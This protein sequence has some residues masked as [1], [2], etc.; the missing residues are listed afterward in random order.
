MLSCLKNAVTLE[1]KITADFG[2]VHFQ[3]AVLCLALKYCG[4][5]GNLMVC[6]SKGFFFSFIDS[7]EST[8]SQGKRAQQA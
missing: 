2:I 3:N 8:G 4:C 7:H 6:C 5:D 1:E